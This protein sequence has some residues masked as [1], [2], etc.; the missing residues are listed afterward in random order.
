MANNKIKLTKFD[1]LLFHSFY[2]IWKYF[3]EPVN[4]FCLIISIGQVY[5]Y[6]DY[7][8]LLPLSFF[9]I[10]SCILYVYEIK[11]LF[12]E[13][14]IQNNK[15]CNCFRGTIPFYDLRYQ[16]I[17]YLKENDEIPAD[18]T[19]KSGTN[20]LVCEIE[21]T[22]EDIV[23]NKKIGDVLYRG[24][25]IIRSDL[26]EAVPFSLGN[27]CKIYDRYPINKNKTSVQKKILY[28]CMINFF[29]MLFL[30]LIFTFYVKDDNLVS[31]FKKMILLLNTMVPLS[32]QFFFSTAA[33]ILSRR[34]KSVKINNINSF[35]TDPHFIVS[36]KTGT[37]TT[38][39]LKVEM[40]QSDCENTFLNIVI[41]SEIQSIL[42]DD[43]YTLIKSDPIE[44]CLLNHLTTNQQLIVN[45]ESEIKIRTDNQ[46]MIYD[47]I[48]RKDYDYK[49]EVKCS[50][51]FHNQRYELHVQ[52]TPESINRYSNGKLDKYLS[53]LQKDVPKN[54]YRR[55]IA[56]GMKYLDEV[57]NFNYSDLQFV[58]LYTLYD[59]FVED[60][61]L[62]LKK[63][64]RDFT[65]LTGDSE[66]SAIEVA[67][68]I[69]LSDPVLI[70]GRILENNSSKYIDNIINSRNRI[71]YR[72]SP[73][74][75]QLYIKLLQDNFNKPVMM[76]GDGLNDM[77]AL[78]QADI[79]I[80]IKCNK[81]VE[82]VSDMIVDTWTL[83][84]HILKD[85][86]KKTKSIINVAN[87]VLYKH[88]YS[89]FTSIMLLLLSGFKVIKDPTSPYLISLFNGTIFIFM[90]VYCYFCDTK[91]T[92][93][94]STIRLLFFNTVA[95]ILIFRFGMSIKVNILIQIIYLSLVL[96]RIENIH[97]LRIIS[98]FLICLWFSVFIF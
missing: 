22:G 37:I 13:Q 19:I 8:S 57:D 74:G 38:G 96:N 42:T 93:N 55:M 59:Y 72:S 36:D 71:I 17:V 21:L 9:C 58:S 27:K 73:Q 6:K 32:L 47:R 30:A 67:K 40:I 61:D 39:K 83:I 20:I 5:E 84:P 62:A 95:S 41:C 70:D 64:N 1:N 60:V 44:Q 43:R 25:K 80:A 66:K 4:F 77:S 97:Y 79:G 65:L 50:I 34:I 49:T 89:A 87:F 48:Y 7:R 12:Y 26:I 91:R 88:T 92:Y 29:M 76:I 3:T 69:G 11:L 51:I 68:V 94:F 31:N 75:K 14:A 28:R 98:L 15:I 54:T 90:C 33:I 2:G 10:I 24:T 46:D 18:L 53:N 45:S 63:L 82:N 78:M 35:Q 16:D 86:R 23:I 56:H 81:N 52:G 85:C